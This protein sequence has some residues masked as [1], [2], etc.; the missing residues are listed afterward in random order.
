[1][2][3]IWLIIAAI[4]YSRA[5]AHN[6]ARRFDKALLMLAKIQ[7]GG[8]IGA[9]VTLFRADIYHRMGNF[10]KAREN[11][12]AF[13]DRDLEKI[14]SQKDRKYLKIYAQYFGNHAARKSGGEVSAEF[15]AI[16]VKIA[17]ESAS[18]LCRAEF[19]PP[20]M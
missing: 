16:D 1:M 4:Q 2:D 12:T 20:S 10:L 9:K 8:E 15:G 6:N 18:A 3:K 14:L 11:Y 7:V 13:L 5:A 17:S 19:T